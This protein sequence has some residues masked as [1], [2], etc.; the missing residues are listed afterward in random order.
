MPPTKVLFVCTGN[1]FRSQMAEGLLRHFG[2]DAVEVSS[3]GARPGPGVHPAAVRC[4]KE[5]GLDIS[6]QQSKPVELFLGQPFDYVITVCDQARQLC[7]V[8]PGASQSLHWS[9][10]DP[11]EA[12][13]SEAERMLFYRQIR[14]DLAARIRQW[15][16]T[17]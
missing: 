9:I 16:E 6:G 13:G 10:P 2:G 1:V 17:V 4:M 3:A 15:L 12:Q 5:I 14:D 7:P 8:F 11:V